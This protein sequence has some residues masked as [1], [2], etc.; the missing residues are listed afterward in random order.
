MSDQHSAESRI[1]IQASAEALFEYLDDHR[2]VAGHMLQPSMTMLGGRMS[3]EFDQAEG[4][5]IGGWITH[6]RWADAP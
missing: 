5:E 1:R 6:D 4:R 2:R 3:Y